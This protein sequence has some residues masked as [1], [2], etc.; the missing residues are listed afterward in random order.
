[1]LRPII[2]FAFRHSIGLRELVDAAKEVYIEIAIK[3]FK[4]SN[5]KVTVTRLSVATGVHRKDADRIVNKGGL[6]KEEE[7]QG[8]IT[9]KVISQWR[10]DKRFL[11]K[12]GR[13]RVLRNEGDDSEFARLVRLVNRE[14]KSGTVLFDLERIGAVHR[15]PSG[16]K[17]KAKA[18]VPDRDSLEGYRMLAGDVEDLMEAVTLN[19]KDGG[20]ILPNYHAKAIVDNVALKDLPRVRDWLFKACSNFHKKV[21]DYVSQYDLDT[22]PNRE[23][24][25]GGKVAIGIFSRLEPAPSNKKAEE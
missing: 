10:R 4:H 14:V 15:S 20:K 5:Q 24:K 2:R 7:G 21:V 18:Y 25:G 23:G 3:E 1:M 6:D 8:R 17:L 16:L 22:N 9:G 13:P 19:I 12:G 11:D